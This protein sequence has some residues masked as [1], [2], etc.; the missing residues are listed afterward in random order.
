MDLEHEAVMRRYEM[1]GYEKQFDS[2]QIKMAEAQNL[3][4]GHLIIQQDEK[5]CLTTGPDKGCKYFGKEQV[6]VL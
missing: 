5:R 3:G 4:R 1:N 6:H 2:F